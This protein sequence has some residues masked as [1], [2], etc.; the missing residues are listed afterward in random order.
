MK[1]NQNID[2]WNQFTEMIQTYMDQNDDKS[3][4]VIN[5]ESA[6]S[7]KTLL[8]LELNENG[9]DHNLILEEISKYLRYSARTTH[10]QFNNQL[11]AGANFES[12]LGEITTFITNTTM[13]TYEVAPVGTLIESKL[14]D[15]LNKKIGYTDGDG[16]MLTGGSNANLLALHC[17]R[18]SHVAEIKYKGNQGLRMCVFVSE[19]AHYSFKKAVMLMGIGLDNLILIKSDGN[20]KM[21]PS[22]LEEKILQVKSEGRLPLM[23]ASTCGTTVKGAF[24]PVEENQAIADKYKVWHHLD[25]AWGGAALFSKRLG[26]KLSSAHK[27][28]SFTFDA[29]KVLGTGIITSFLLTKRKGTIESANSGGGSEYLFHHYESAEYDTGK[30]SLQCGRKVDALKLWLSWKSMGHQGMTRYV[31]TQVEKMEFFR[32]LIIENP[33]LKLICDPEYLNVCFQVIPKNSSVEINQYNLDLRF[34]VVKSGRFLVNF[35]SDKNGDVYFRFV[36]ANPTTQK[37]D[38][39]HFLSELLEIAE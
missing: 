16:I 12:L 13:S 26:Y 30:S 35:S 25:G 24:D 19:Q 15:E 27:A 23:I 37:Q 17:A 6:K 1:F 34:N 20:G 31:D 39:Q 29:H 38:I 4:P 7:L 14:I 2:I 10:P 36:F 5:Y 9:V 11:Q 22:D 21:I 8:N 33:R 18:N 32:D 3:T 28:D